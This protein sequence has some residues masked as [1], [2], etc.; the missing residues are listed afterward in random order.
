[1]LPNKNVFV[2]TIKVSCQHELCCEVVVRALMVYFH[3]IWVYRSG[4]GGAGGAAL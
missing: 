2:A 1:M 4:A 3:C